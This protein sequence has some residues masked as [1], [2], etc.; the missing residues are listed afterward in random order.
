MLRV[1]ARRGRQPARCPR[2]TFLPPTAR[3][4]AAG[5]CV[6]GPGAPREKLFL[7][8][9]EAAASFPGRFDCRA[10][11]LRP[12]AEDN[13]FWPTF[14][15]QQDLQNTPASSKQRRLPRQD[16]IL[17][18]CNKCNQILS[19][20]TRSPCKWVFLGAALQGGVAGAHL[21]VGT[22]AGE[23]Y[24]G[25]GKSIEWSVEW[26]SVS[27]KAREAWAPCSHCCIKTPRVHSLDA[28]CRPPPTRVSWPLAPPHPA[29]R[30]PQSPIEAD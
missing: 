11:E 14:C 29:S 9:K 18:P 5:L 12:A 20:C 2:G 25:R 7:Y 13:W 6:L 16:R 22:D 1:R 8:C 30:S 21:C 3:Q 10:A 28:A 23:K 15:V 4:R 19:C 17:A 24:E 26:W 27:G